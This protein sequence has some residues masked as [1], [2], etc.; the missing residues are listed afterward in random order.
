VLELGGAACLP[1]CVAAVLGAQRVVMTDFPAD[2]VI[3]NIDSV[4]RTNGL[5]HCAIAMPHIWGRDIGALLSPISKVDTTEGAAH[6]GKTKYQLVILAELLWKDTYPLHRDLLL[7]VSQ[8]LDPTIGV[9]LV[10]FAHRPTESH[11][12]SRD[13]EF[14]MLAERDFGLQAV[15]ICSSQKY[16]DIGETDPIDVQLWALILP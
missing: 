13:L 9:A 12:T 14:F 2:G 10:S 6:G 1:S 15:H 11:P 8:A 16:C 3:E 4:I 5:Q 7:T